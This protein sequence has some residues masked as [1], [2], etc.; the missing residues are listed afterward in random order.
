MF[1][2]EIILPG[3]SRWAPAA[4]IFI[5]RYDSWDEAEGDLI[6]T[7]HRPVEGNMTI[8]AEIGVM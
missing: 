3:L 2:W 6:Y 1:R 8:V 5:L 4:I 7:V